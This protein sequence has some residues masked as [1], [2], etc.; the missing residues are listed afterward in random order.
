MQL[1]DR[2]WLREL[3]Q[4]REL[5]YFLAWR[6]VKVRYKQTM[7]GVVWAV[8]QPVATMLVFL[9]LFGKI[10]SIPT[11]GTPHAVFYYTALVPWIYF[12]GTLATCANSLVSNTNLLTKVYFPR[13][14]LPAAVVLSGLVDFGIGMFLVVGLLAYYHIVPNWHIVLLP[15]VALLLLLLAYS[16]GVILAAVTVKYRDVKYATPFLIQLGLFVTPIIYPPSMVPE[17]YRPLL[18]L[19]PLTG[20]IDAFRAIFVPSH[21]FEWGL[22][23]VSALSTLLLLLVGTLYFRAA[24]RSFADTI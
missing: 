1:I 18:L 8:I 5:F 12:S 3:W 16:I 23:G 14:V 21:P 2:E 6:D 19:N 13:N 22:L 7:L 17:A 15:L 4:Y 20:I 24:E 11:D 9:V 10:A